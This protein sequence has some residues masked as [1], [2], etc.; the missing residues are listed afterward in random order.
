MTSAEPASL[1]I[2]RARPDEA[3]C[4]ADLYWD[5]RRDNEPAIP[6][7]VHP[8]DDV[9]RWVREQLLP[10]YDVWV[11]AAANSAGSVVEVIGF[12]A[13]GRPDWI[14][15]L[16]IRSDWTGRGLGARFIDLARQELTGPIQLWT[17]QSNLGALR[18][19]QRQGFDEVE[20]TEG[21]NEEGAPDVRLLCAPSVR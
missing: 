11:A 1:E 6:A 17:F 13:L 16:Y 3:R 10:T 12:M 14:E 20:R 15:H 5:V 8:R 7:M 9:R 2:R 4:I 18:F 19:Y 21:D